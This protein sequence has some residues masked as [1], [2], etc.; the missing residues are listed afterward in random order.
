MRDSFVAYRDFRNVTKGIPDADVRARMYDAL[1]DYALDDIEPKL[2]YPFNLMLEALLGSVNRAA[3]RY[4]KTVE[5]GKTGGRPTK[6]IVPEVAKALYTELGTWDKVAK[7]LNVS[8]SKLYSAKAA[9]ER[10][11]NGNSKNSENSKN[12]YVNDNDY[13]YGNVNDNVN[14]NVINITDNKINNN[15]EE[16]NPASVGTRLEAVPPPQG[17]EWTAR[18]S[19]LDGVHYRRCRRIGGYETR[20]IRLD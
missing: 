16:E 2:E 9:W 1:F 3:K 15:N 14:D 5:N 7:E 12:L 13:V 18:I 8:L 6:W 4:E 11:E 10:K 20:V 17:F 19:D